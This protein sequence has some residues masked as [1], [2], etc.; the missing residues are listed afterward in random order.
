MRY[1]LSVAGRV[2]YWSLS[3]PVKWAV[4]SGRVAMAV[5]GV[6]GISLAAVTIYFR[7]VSTGPTHLAVLVLSPLMP[8]VST[9]TGS[10]HYTV[11]FP[12]P[13][14]IATVAYGVACA[15]GRALVAYAQSK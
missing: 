11:E 10:E 6:L 4:T 15:W 14:C 8:V 12:I 3:H 13:L 2:L 1:G 9:S 7:L 5:V